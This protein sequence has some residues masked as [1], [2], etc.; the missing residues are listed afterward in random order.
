M[1]SDILDLPKLAEDCELTVQAVFRTED[2]CKLFAQRLGEKQCV[3]GLRWLVHHFLVG[4]ERGAQRQM[5][6][7]ARELFTELAQEQHPRPT[8]RD[9][10]HRV[11]AID[12]W[13]AAEEPEI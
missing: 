6:A 13:K 8:L 11:N 9:V 10:E 2:Q 7:L 12:W 3:N 4:F 5:M 1:A